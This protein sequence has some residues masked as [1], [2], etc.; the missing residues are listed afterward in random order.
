[1]LLASSLDANCRSARDE[2]SHL[3]EEPALIHIN[4]VCAGR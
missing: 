2:A 4:N 1:L 3:A